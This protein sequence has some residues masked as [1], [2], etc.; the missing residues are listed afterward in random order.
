MKILVLGSG[1][2]E[3]AMIHAL[4]RSPS[5]HKL[6]A[7]PG[8]DGMRGLCTSVPFT[9]NADLVRF[10]REQVD[11]SVVGSSRFVEE[12]TVDAL[13]TAGIPV[14]G[15]AADAGRIE[16]SK[17]FASAFLVK[18]NIPSPM[19]QVVAN[20]L[21]AERFLQENPWVKVVK[22]NGFSRGLGV[23]LVDTPD[24]A[25]AAVDRLLKKHGPPIILQERLT[26]V[27][28]SYSILTDGQ[29]WVSF[30]SSREYKRAGNG[31]T[32]AT[33][34]GIGSVCPF[35]GLTP[36]LE[37]RIRTRIVIPTVNGLQADKL[38]YRGFL[39]LHLIMTSTGPKVLE[40]NARLGDP[41]TQSILVRFRGN[42]AAL[43]MDC[44]LGRLDATGSEVAFGR[45]SAVSVVLARAGYPNDE[46]AEPSIQG[47]DELSD[48]QV[49]HS[50]S[51][52]HEAER[53]FTFRGGRLITLSA[54]G[55]TLAEARR[56][57]YADLSRLTLR[58][59]Q[60]RSDIGAES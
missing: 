60:Y 19:T 14:I 16:T 35:P 24:E 50:G 58:N 43:L 30:S 25:L 32:G 34:G 53:R 52:W 6:Y 54:V 33:T 13:M 2:R 31:D 46:S 45:N 39:S 22:C 12:G 11:L 4:A 28:C 23:E 41:E 18:H 40:I 42:L 20:R 27:E 48:T 15:P 29:Q 55:E 7:C 10:A 1:A 17:A 36:E 47:L 37:E 56:K 38:I 8:N 5:V 9:S 44:A 59:V 21:E 57:C 26:G 3:H 51:V 49:F